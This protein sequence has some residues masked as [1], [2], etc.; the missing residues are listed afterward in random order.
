MENTVMAKHGIRGW[1]D[2]KLESV[3][4]V[5]WTIQSCR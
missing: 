1:V 3:T 5:L 2:T 4:S